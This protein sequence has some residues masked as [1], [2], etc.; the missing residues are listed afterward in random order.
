MNPLALLTL[1]RAGV[2]QVRSGRHKIFDGPG[3]GKLSPG[4][5]FI[6]LD[7]ENKYWRSTSAS[8]C[9]VMLATWVTHEKDHQS[10]LTFRRAPHSH[11][12]A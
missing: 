8:H 1:Q 2:R 6:E 7:Q 10:V 4:G 9:Q 5:V 12:A 11:L 3:D